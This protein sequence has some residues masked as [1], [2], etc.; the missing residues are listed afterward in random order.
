MGRQIAYPCNW[1]EVGW[2][3]IYTKISLGGGIPVNMSQTALSAGHKSL[4]LFLPFS[5]MKPFLQAVARWPSKPHFQHLSS[6]MR[7]SYNAE[8]I[9][10]ET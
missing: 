5:S 7:W 9:G 8:G 6:L 1:G 4:D 3:P 2:E 10:I